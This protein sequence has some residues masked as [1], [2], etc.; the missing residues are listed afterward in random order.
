M[1][2]KYFSGSGMQMPGKFA[3][4]HFKIGKFAIRLAFIA[5]LVHL[6]F[7]IDFSRLSLQE[8]SLRNLS[9]RGLS[10]QSGVGGGSVSEPIVVETLASLEFEY[11]IFDFDT[12]SRPR[13][14]IFSSYSIQPGDMIGDLARKFGLNQ[15]TII[16]V[17]NIR[18]SR[19]LQIGQPLRIPNQDG[20]YHVV[21]PTDTLHSIAERYRT[22]PVTLQVVNMLFSE[23][24]RPGTSIFIPDARLDSATLQEINGDMFIWPV[25]GRFITS[26]YGWRNS[27]FTGR[28]QFHTGIDIRGSTGTPVWAA[29][30]GRVSTAGWNNVFGNYVII[31][32][33]SGWRTLYAHLSVIRVRRGDFVRAN[34]RIGDVGS[35]GMSTGPHLHFTVFRNGVTVNPRTVLR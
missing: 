35:T 18:N 19:L 12:L 27:P 13:T 21:S 2:A 9:L 10:L 14:L 1:F 31:D 8:D 26:P 5:C 30:A 24:L 11:E 25:P 16:S 33:H 3:G 22:D 17:N 34:Q 28:R 7:N 29:N 15:D 23:D 20:I 6:S 32:H 4:G